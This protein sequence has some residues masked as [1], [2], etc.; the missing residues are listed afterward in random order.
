MLPLSSAQGSWCLNC[1]FWTKAKTGKWKLEDG[2]W[3][4]HI[5][6]VVMGTPNQRFSNF[7]FLFSSFHARPMAEQRSNLDLEFRV[8]ESG[9]RLDIF[10]ARQMPDWS[11]S[12]I[13]RLIRSGL[14]R[15]CER[16]ARKGGESV[17]A[18]D[19]IAVRAEREELAATP[20]ALPLS[21]VFEDE[22][23]LVVNKPAGM[24]VHVGAGVK[25]GTLVNALLHHI[26]TLSTG[27]DVS[28]PGIVH[29][30]DKMTS[31]L[32]VVAKNDATHRRLAEQFKSRTV[33][34]TYTLLVHGKVTSDQGQISKP[35]GR[36][37]VR[38]T[39]M[40]AGGLRP[41][42]AL[43]RYEVRRRF[44]DF[45]L[46]AA[47]P[48]TGRTHQI[49]V[50]FAALGHP[51]VGD[52]TYGAPSKLRVAGREVP[53]LW[54]TFLHAGSLEFEHPRLHRPMSFSAPLPSELSEFLR[55][56]GA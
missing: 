1:F 40:K 47:H 49:R 6:E 55:D 13:Q 39:R 17:R 53:T 20:E 29:R 35:V 4:I 32:V 9:E 21:I 46:L 30:L 50:H 27:G 33:H 31:G 11:R 48:E 54:R 16:H 2:N 44:G 28:R 22:D 15:V 56:L 12:Q 10:L 26:G 7:H 34:K 19:I 5:P 24:V 52:T 23:L 51:I 36:D 18:G 41:R 37:P 45:T 43:T 3:E 25:S 42:E 38:R 8:S 14:V